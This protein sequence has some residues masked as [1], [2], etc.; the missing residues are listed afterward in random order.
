MPKL[1]PRKAL[2]RSIPKL[3][4]HYLKA[5]A[6]LLEDHNLGTDES[7]HQARKNLKRVRAL[8]KLIEAAA[9]KSLHALRNRISETARTLSETRDAV[10]LVECSDKLRVYL[11]ARQ[12]ED[13]S[14]HLHEAIAR[15][16]ELMSLE[17]PEPHALTLP[18]AAV[19]RKAIKELRKMNFGDCNQD[20][21][22][23]ATGRR[24]NHDKARQTLKTC[25]HGGHPEAF[26][27]LRK[28]AQATFFQAGFLK[29]AW[30]L[31]MQAE[32]TLAKDITD[33]LGHEHDIEVMTKLLQVEPHL[34]GA[35]A[36][37][38]RLATLLNER[39][40]A[41][42]HEAINTAEKLYAETGKTEAQRLALL[43]QQ[44]GKPRK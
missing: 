14:Q 37:K 35:I 4:G 27:D 15:R 24:K 29:S 16:R 1:D 36:D 2:S 6:S 38:D 21:D 30:P 39:R 19:C 7:I 18:V 44:A 26:H 31:A 11:D 13:M 17:A 34:F 23:I 5:A 32:A 12:S 20:C 40:A 42:R 8:L 28:C 43:W 22:I 10:A 3:A 41:L 9:P 33:T 25:H